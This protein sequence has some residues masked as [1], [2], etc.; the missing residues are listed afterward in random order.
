[1]RFARGNQNVDKIQQ[2]ADYIDQSHSMVAITGAGISLAGGGI[3]Y[4]QLSKTV[5]A[6]S[7][8]SDEFLRSY[9]KAMHSYKPSFSLAV[10]NA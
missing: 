8:G 10:C 4:S 7:F 5:R 9:V 3:T 1:M 6:G 2:L